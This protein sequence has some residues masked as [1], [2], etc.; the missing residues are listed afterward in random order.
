MRLL[1]W[2]WALVVVA[3]GLAVTNCSTNQYFDTP[4]LGAGSVAGLDYNQMC[5][6]V[7]P[8]PCDERTCIKCPAKTVPSRDGTV[9]LPCDNSTLGIL[10]NDCRCPSSMVLVDRQQ[11]NNAPLPAKTCL[12]CNGS[13]DASG[14]V[15]TA[16]PANMVGGPSGCACA[17]GYALTGVATIGPVKCISQ[18]NQTAIT[19]MYPLQTATQVTFQDFAAPESTTP[20]TITSGLMVHSFSSAITRV[21]QHYF[22]SA[23][24]GCYYYANEEANSACQVLSNLC[25]LSVFAPKSSACS[26]LNQL[27]MSSRLTTSNGILGWTATLPF[28]EYTAGAASVLA[29]TN[30]DLTMSFSSQANPGT[31]DTL[32]YIVASYGLNGS[33]LGWSPLTTQ[34]LLCDPTAR[35]NYGFSLEWLRFG[36]GTTFAYSCD[37]AP[38]FAATATVVFYELYLVDT[39]NDRALVPVPVRVVNYRDNRGN[40]VNANRAPTDVENNQLTH[41]FYVLDAASGVKA[42]YTSPSVVYYASSISLVV[43]TQESRASAI[44]PPCLTIRYTAT[45]TAG[46]VGTVFQVQYTSSTKTFWS[47]ALALF[48]VA[49]VLSGC[50]VLLQYYTW[51]RRNTRSNNDVVATSSTLFFLSRSLTNTFSTWTFALLAVLT[52]Y[53]LVFFK[54]QT[55]VYTFLPEYDS[56][57]GLQNEYAPFETVLVITFVAKTVALLSAVYEQASVEMFF[58]DWEKARGSPE[59]PSPVSVWRTI[60]VA[61]E[62]AELQTARGSSLALT[63]LGVLWILLGCEYATLASPQPLV[64]AVVHGPPNEYLRF[65]NVAFWWLVLV[66]SQWLWRWLI[67][68]RWVSEPR[69]LKF[70]DLCTLAKVSCVLLDEAYHGYYLHCRSPYA[71][72][73]TSMLD[74]TEQLK[75]EEAGLTSSRGLDGGPDECQ[76]F[77]LFVTKAWRRKYMKLYGAEEQKTHAAPAANLLDRRRPN[78]LLTPARKTPPSTTLLQAGH[79]L[80]S[81]LQNF[82]DNHDET[83]R[84]KM[85][86]GQTCMA[87]VLRIPPDMGSGKTSLLVP[88]VSSQ[89]TSV[90]FLGL[91][92]DLMLWNILVFSVSDLWWGNH[93]ISALCTFIAEG[94]MVRLRQHLGERN[95]ARRTLVDDRFLV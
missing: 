72:A 88:D 27:A 70:I 58:V 49:C 35:G 29:Q 22:L 11:V 2:A 17:A 77:E 26:L 90:L 1:R 9:C 50:S 10:G 87:R 18:A 39:A 62:W 86:T 69:H 73:D 15:C 4:S 31:T 81:F 7:W 89:F 83:H 95:V 47:V 84:W 80:N 63:L 43:Q 65:A 68:E 61:N 52:G 91:E 66:V 30:I 21:F 46:V 36:L 93:A 38:V 19:Q 82:V 23:A 37:L 28:L 16:C 24:I 78:T 48:V 3:D 5:W 8:K 92:T 56:S 12:T 74:I 25:V 71:F 42:G 53:Y 45:Q 6:N 20:L 13:V 34:L 54:L 76:A 94:A 32:Q 79:R 14:Y 44:Y 59:A 55:A 51:Q 67:Y 57:Y 33:F 64:Y 75:Q 41:R 60:L 40:L 85:V